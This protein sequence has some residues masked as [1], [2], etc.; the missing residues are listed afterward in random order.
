[1]IPTIAVLGTAKSGKTTLIEY[2]ISNL[3]REGF[4]IGTIKHI[5]EAG[6]SIDAKG[7]DTWRHARAGAKI[8][9]AAAPKEL[10]IIRKKETS[11]NDLKGIVNLIED[12]KLDLLIIEGF[13]SVVSQRK[14][15][16]K[17]VAAKSEEELRQTLRGTVDPILAITGPLA[18]L[19]IVPAGVKIPVID[20]K[21]EGK[22]LL[23][24]VKEAL[25]KG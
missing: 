4:R 22:K 19:K 17:I 21:T 23:E 2:L 24:I 16:L 20:I 14:D 11:E 8:V 13:R 1:M 12:E 7:K 6:F 5:H 9:V 15:I 18:R 25:A 3:S 10:A